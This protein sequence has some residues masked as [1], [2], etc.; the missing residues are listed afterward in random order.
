MLTDRAVK[1][2]KPRANPYKIADRDGLYLFVGTSGLKSWRWNTTVAGK[3]K[4]I[5]HGRYPETSLAQARELHREAR[6]NRDASN[7]AKF[8]DI[9]RSWLKLK[10]PE[11]LSANNRRIMTFCVIDELIPAFDKVCVTD[12]KRARLI[13]VLGLWRDR[14]G[15]LKRVAGYLAGIFNHAIDLGLLEL[16]PATNLVR[17]FP[18]GDARP[19]PCVSPDQAGALIRAIEQYPEDVTRIG[20][21]M[22][23]YTFVR[24]QELL[25]IRPDEIRRERDG[26]TVWVIPVERMK[27]RKTPHVVPL[28]RQVVDLI[29]MRISQQGIGGSDLL[30]ESPLHKGQAVSKNTLVFALYRLGYKGSMTV[31]GFRALASTAL[32]ESGM[33]SAD[34]IERQLAH[35]ET[36]AVRA[37]YHRAEYLPERRR[38][39]Q[40]WA[41]WIDTQKNKK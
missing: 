39:M 36:N 17:A 34:A 5:V 31:H 26:Q 7:K 40:W 24:T 18:R 6:R 8:S 19:H 1:T 16:N 13:E 41:D 20:L 2:A 3:Q 22:V 12:I 25:G 37:A 30:L 11:L 23:A 28:A 15:T 29:D 10:V 4:T 9:A 27:T 35:K 32:N 21:M 14:P 33:W 38:M